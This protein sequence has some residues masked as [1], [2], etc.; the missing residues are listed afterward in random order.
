MRLKK[1]WLAAFSISV[2]FL[3]L[4]FILLDFNRLRLIVWSDWKDYHKLM[5]YRGMYISDEDDSTIVIDFRMK[6]KFEK[7]LPELKSV[8]ENIAKE[9][10]SNTNEKRNLYF[11]FYSGWGDTFQIYVYPDTED[12]K[13]IIEAKGVTLKEIA[14][15]YPETIDLN[16]DVQSKHIN[17]ICKFNNLSKVNLWR[18]LSEEEKLF[19]HSKFPDCVIEESTED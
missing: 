8:Y 2:I 15:I 17:D 11:Y 1:E 18:K 3:G 6:K 13:M 12:I 14:E 16:A 7:C 9:Y 10:Y 19:I 5:S 4:I